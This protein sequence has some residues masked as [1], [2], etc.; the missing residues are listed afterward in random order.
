MEIVPKGSFVNLCICVRS[1]KITALGSLHTHQETDTNNTLAAHGLEE[2]FFS[3]A[4]V[5]V[6]SFWWEIGFGVTYLRI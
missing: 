6:F 5:S 1:N 4:V 2:L 3:C